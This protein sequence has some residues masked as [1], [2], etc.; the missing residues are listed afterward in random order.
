[1]QVVRR[2]VVVQ[3]TAVSH[4]AL[5]PSERIS[6]Q[7]VPE[8]HVQP[9]PFPLRN[10]Q[11]WLVHIHKMLLNTEVGLVHKHTKGTNAISHQSQSVAQQAAVAA[12]AA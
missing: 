1:M 11:V 3:L 9:K 4:E 10:T 8:P 7:I 12:E 6:Q 2:G 5:L